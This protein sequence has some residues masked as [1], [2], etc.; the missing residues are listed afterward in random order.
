MCSPVKM[1]VWCVADRMVRMVEYFKCI[2]FPVATRTI[3]LSHGQFHAVANHH[4]IKSCHDV[5][6]CPTWSHT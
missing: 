2:H 5:D 3:I 6:P 4:G 1:S